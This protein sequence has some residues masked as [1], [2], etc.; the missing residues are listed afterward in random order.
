MSIMPNIPPLFLGV[1]NVMDAVEAKCLV[2]KV[3][4]NSK[5]DMK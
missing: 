1:K 5:N 2:S 3:N 4:S